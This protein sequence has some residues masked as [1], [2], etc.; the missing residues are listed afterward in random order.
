MAC[1]STWAVA[2]RRCPRRAA[3]AGPRAFASAVSSSALV[4]KLSRAPRSGSPRPLGKALQQDFRAMLSTSGAGRR[5]RPATRAPPPTP[6]KRAGPA[7]ASTIP[8][9]TRV[10]AEVPSTPQEKRSAGRARGAG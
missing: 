1:T 2:P 5:S 6:A 10:A 8:I 7:A 3:V 4:E 9:S